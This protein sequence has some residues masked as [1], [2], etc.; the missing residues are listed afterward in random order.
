MGADLD[1]AIDA[2]RAVLAAL[3]P[4]EPAARES[5]LDYVF[6]RLDISAPRPKSPETLPQYPP[7]PQPP[8]NPVQPSS[9][10]EVHIKQLKEEKQPKS[11]IEMAALVAYYLSHLAPEGE[12]KK[13]ISAKDLETY[14]KIAE[15]RLPSQLAFT[16]PN[17]KKAG[18]LDSAGTGEYKLNP[19]GYN[20][21]VHSMPRSDQ[22]SAKRTRRKKTSTKKVAVS[23]TKRSQKRNND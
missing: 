15:F 6:K 18:Y 7:L 12:R 5:V 10:L 11:A 22:P 9:P 16:L 3:Q 23:R 1:K 4:L 13:T 8:E 2:I 19:V 20:L 17:A 14:F 21:V